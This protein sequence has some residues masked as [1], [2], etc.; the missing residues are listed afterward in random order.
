MKT[1]FSV[2]PRKTI[3]K[4]VLH[5]FFNDF[6]NDDFFNRSLSSVIGNDTSLNFPS[7]NV[8]EYENQFKLELAAPGL[9]KEDFNIEIE[10]DQIKISAEVKNEEEETTGNYRRREFNYT[11]FKRTFRIP[12]NIDLEEINANYEQGVLSI[13]LP[14]KEENT[15]EK[16][17]RIDIS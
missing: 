17:R 6:M 14:T 11:S 8:V 3:H 16:V 9:K 4:P 7:V 12:E 15:A 13:S 1:A 5:S 10:E 2:R